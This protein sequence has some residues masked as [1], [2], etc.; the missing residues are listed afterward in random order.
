MRLTDEELKDV[1]L[2]AL[3]NKILPH[4]GTLGFKPATKPKPGVFPRKYARRS[5]DR[6]DLLNF[7]FDKYGRASFTINFRSLENVS[8]IAKFRPGWGHALY[9]NCYFRAS[10]SRFGAKWFSL[11]L[12]GRSFLRDRILSNLIL[13]VRDR[14]DD[15]SRFLS[16]GPPSPFL[17]E[18]GLWDGKMVDETWP[19]PPKR[20]LSR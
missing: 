4:L 20:R 19:A 7:Q 11:G 5:T 12:L 8:D 16:G 14:L 9:G 13:R 18:G 6:I 1:L 17:R 15:V 2:E 3:Q 10:D